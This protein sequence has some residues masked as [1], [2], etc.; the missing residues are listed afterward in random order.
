M[1]LRSIQNTGIFKRKQQIALYGEL[2]VEEAMDMS[3]RLQNEWTE[4]IQWDCSIL[5]G[6]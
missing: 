2:A 4:R 1:T 5:K 6:K 3:N